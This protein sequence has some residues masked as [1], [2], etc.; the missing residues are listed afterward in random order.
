MFKK[1]MYTYTVLLK[2]KLPPP[3][4]KRDSYREKRDSYRKKRDSSRRKRELSREK[5]LVSRDCTAST[6]FSINGCSQE[7]LSCVEK[8]VEQTCVVSLIFSL[9]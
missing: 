8:I 9:R 1:I 6:A 3:R 2:C 7:G 5:F 4:E